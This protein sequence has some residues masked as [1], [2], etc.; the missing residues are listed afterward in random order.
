MTQTVN[1]IENW[2]AMARPK[3]SRIR[4]THSC[5]PVS[6]QVGIGPSRLASVAGTN[7]F[8]CV[9]LIPVRRRLTP[10][11]GGESSHAKTSPLS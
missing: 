9:D 1:T 7:R 3:W 5:G 6:R 11:S 10:R 2:R 4:G 8:L